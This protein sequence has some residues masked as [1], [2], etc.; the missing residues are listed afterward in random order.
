MV[1][2]GQLLFT[3]QRSNHSFIEKNIMGASTTQ[4]V[5]GSVQHL[6]YSIADAINK[7]TN[8]KKS[9]AIIKGNGELKD[10]YIAKF[11]LQVRESY[12][13]GPF[14]LDSV[15]KKSHRKFRLQKYDL[16]IIAKLLKDSL[17]LKTGFR[18]IHHKWWKNN[19]VN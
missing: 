13:I 11:L 10:I 3:Q 6:E 7:I 16:A 12:H 1:F 17:K 18:S 4:K 19:V 9:I 5:I 8:E 2:L 14:T 15:A